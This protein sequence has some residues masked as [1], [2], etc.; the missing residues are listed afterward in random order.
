[1]DRE[2][3]AGRLVAAVVIK[4]VVEDFLRAFGPGM[5]RALDQKPGLLLG[6]GARR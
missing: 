2:I 5:S 6:G 3:G 4:L 1:V